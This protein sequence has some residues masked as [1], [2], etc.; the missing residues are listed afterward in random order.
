[1]MFDTAVGSQGICPTGWHIPGTDEWQT[2]VTTV[3][4]DGNP[5]KWAGAG[6][7]SGIG[8]N[9][10]GFSG[11]LG[12]IGTNTFTFSSIDSTGLLWSSRWI[13]STTDAYF[14]YVNGY[15][16]STGLGLLARDYAVG[17]RC[18]EN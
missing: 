5:L 8:T 13:G 6:G 10:T 16:N 12:G 7:G 18:L 2:L 9:T 1:M 3:S 17:I 11:L 4:N 14:S 15:D